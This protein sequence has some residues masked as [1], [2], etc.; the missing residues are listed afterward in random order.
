M[1][2]M[3]GHWIYSWIFGFGGLGAVVSVAAWALWFFC[4]AFLLPIKSLL[5]HI[6]VGATIFTFAS[7]YFYTKGY[8]TGYAVAIH[9]IAA[10]DQRAAKAAE[11]AKTTVSDCFNSGGTWNVEDATCAKP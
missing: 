6:A 8:N 1:I 9:A 10:Q 11:T 4:P 7:T 5:L 3:I 2:S